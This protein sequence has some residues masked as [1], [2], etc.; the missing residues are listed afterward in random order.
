MEESPGPYV[1]SPQNYIC[2]H[3]VHSWISLYKRR[4]RIHVYMHNSIWDIY[5][6]VGSMIVSYSSF[7]FFSIIIVTYMSKREGKWLLHVEE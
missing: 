7:D 6:R 1:I 2:I 4:Y 5:T 3:V